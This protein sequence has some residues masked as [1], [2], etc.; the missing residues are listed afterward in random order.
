MNTN[1]I[2]LESD[3]QAA[4]TLQTE[5]ESSS[6][7]QCKIAMDFAQVSSFLKVD[8]DVKYIF[9]VYDV[10]S[11]EEQLREQRVVDYVRRNYPFVRV[12][13]IGSIKKEQVTA[14][15]R[16]VL[17]FTKDDS[18]ELTSASTYR[19]GQPRNFG[20]KA[21]LSDLDKR[22]MYVIGRKNKKS[23]VGH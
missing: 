5:I 14:C 16:K 15:S 11:N 4:Q 7:I 3:P 21:K 23:D 17:L 12:C 20:L 10:S 19:T 9:C 6:Q 2:I 8:S 18:T 13:S 1:G 22:G